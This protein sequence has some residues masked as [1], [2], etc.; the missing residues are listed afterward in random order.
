[1]E[2][3][4]RRGAWVALVVGAVL[5][6]VAAAAVEVAFD[7][8]EARAGTPTRA[9]I[10]ATQF[11]AGS[12]GGSVTRSPCARPAS[13][14]GGGVVQGGP[15]SSLVVASGPLDGTGVTLETNDGGTWP[16]N[17]EKRLLVTPAVTVGRHPSGM[18]VARGM[19][20]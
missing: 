16:S 12:V 7:A 5:A 2:S 20:R 3:G 15:L 1:M 14:L 4:N 11:S 10:E 13:A 8:G 17:F 19:P 9:T 18:L 6:A